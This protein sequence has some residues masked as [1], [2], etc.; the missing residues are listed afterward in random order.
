MITAQFPKEQNADGEFVRQASH[1]RRH[2]AEPLGADF[3]I[4]LAPEYD[5]RTSDLFG[6]LAPPASG[7]GPKIESDGSRSAAAA[8]AG[9]RG[10]GLPADRV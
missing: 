3:H 8:R 6:S 10:P 5:A 9:R 7:E 2:V 1:F 4:G